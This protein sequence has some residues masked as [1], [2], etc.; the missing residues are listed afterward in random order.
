MRN[1]IYHWI[2]IIAA[3]NLAWSGI[4]AAENERKIDL[5]GSWHF[6]TGDNMEF[7]RK[8][9]ND[10]D[11]EEIRVPGKWEDQGHRDYDGYAW[12]RKNIT[13]PGSLKDDGI[14]LRLGKIDDVDMVY[15][16]GM[17][18]QGL[19]GFP[20]KYNSAFNW[21]RQYLIP[22]DLIDFDRNNVIA[23][24]VY[25]EWGDGGLVS[26][27]VGVYVQKIIR[28]DVDLAGTW[29]FM[30]GDDPEYSEPDYND[31]RWNKIRV[32]GHW[33]PQSYPELNGF[34]WYRKT[35]T[36]P[37]SMKQ[38]KIILVLGRIDDY[39]EVFFNGIRIARSNGFPRT[40]TT[41]VIDSW[42]RERFYYIPDHMIQWNGR[43]TIAVRV[44]DAMYSGGIYEGPIGI[45][46]QRA[47]LQYK[48]DQ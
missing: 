28:L 17:Y 36:V 26:G 20:P 35:V 48:G 42:Q 38:D 4:F 39:D 11:W 44:Y 33:E 29:A 7:A 14:V 15:L 31:A 18:L 40:E 19:G 32:P 9:W 5:R 3:N 21:D 46:S 47:L 2:I 22:H 8:D 10:S 16:N 45:T 6:I 41:L 43:N 30:P 27:P 12:Y 23:I 25:D 1:T 37:A 34:A 24:R 13:I